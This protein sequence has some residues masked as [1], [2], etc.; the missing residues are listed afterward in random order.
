MKDKK[1]MTYL[2]WLSLIFITLR[3]CNVI[4]WSW[5]WVLS[6]LWGYVL[7]KAVIKIVTTDW[8]KGE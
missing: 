4:R 2:N 5:I 7:L 8:K 3:L 6:P 1:G